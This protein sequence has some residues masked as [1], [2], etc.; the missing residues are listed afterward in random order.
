VKSLQK[1]YGREL[2]LVF[3]NFPLI[4]IHPMAE[5]AAEDAEFANLHEQFW[6][7]HDGFYE[8]QDRLAPPLLFELGKERKLP[9]F[10]LRSAIDNHDFGQKIRV[11]LWA[12]YV[13]VLMAHQCFSSTT[14][15][16]TDRTI[17]HPSS[18]LSTAGLDCEGLPETPEKRPL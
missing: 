9:L 18:R 16:T 1:H 13:A 14:S 7:M 12:A 5:P 17:S 8:N 4:E 10:G 11:I 2:R 6:A 15:G 3:R